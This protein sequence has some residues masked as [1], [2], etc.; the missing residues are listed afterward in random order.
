MGLSSEDV[1]AFEANLLY[2]CRIH[3]SPILLVER[4]HTEAVHALPIFLGACKHLTQK[5]SIESAVRKQSDC[6][7]SVALGVEIAPPTA[8]GADH[9]PALPALCHKPLKVM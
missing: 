9:E 8:D 3:L 2:Q 1:T 6:A 4:Q 5:Q 7:I